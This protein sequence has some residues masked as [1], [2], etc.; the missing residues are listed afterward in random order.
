[1]SLSF[2]SALAMICS[3]PAGI[4][5]FIRTGGTGARLRMDSKI[6]PDVL[7]WNGNCPVAISY[8]TAP[9]ENRSVRASNSLAERLPLQQ[10]HGNKGSPIGLV[11]LVDRA[12]IRMI[13]GGRSFGL[14][15]KA[16]ESLCVV[17]KVV[18]KELQCD[19]ATELEVFRLIHDAHPAAA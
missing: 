6:K 11:N 16:A 8:S 9:K 10:F 12:D 7:P 13:Q 17:G 3:K 5:G 2:S 1:M 15:L 14:A 18:G 19:M 4:S